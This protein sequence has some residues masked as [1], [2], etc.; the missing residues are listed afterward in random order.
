MNKI[1][2][3]LILIL[4]FYVGVINYTIFSLTGFYSDV[5]FA[6]LVS[7][8]II[9][10]TIINWKK[11]SLVNRTLKYFSIII[12]FGVMILT[13]L[14]EG[15]VE[16][17]FIVLDTIEIN[18]IKYRVHYFPPQGVWEFENGKIYITKL[19]EML[20]F[21]EKH[22]FYGIP[23]FILEDDFQKKNK[24]TQHKKV[25]KFIENELI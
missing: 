12:S 15:M 11:S 24:K 6:I 20:P 13:F 18:K 5:F 14:V 1:V 16:E 22:Y 4:I 8:I 25:K 7:V 2:T 19:N 9:I 3:F 10:L 17:E 23:K 21:I